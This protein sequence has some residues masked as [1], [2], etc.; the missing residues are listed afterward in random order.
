MPTQEMT[1]K[2]VALR[3]L[4]ARADRYDVREVGGTGLRL[5][6]NP[7]GL[8]T[9]RWVYHSKIGA[10]GTC[11]L[12][13]G[14][15]GDGQNGTITYLQARAKIEAAKAKLQGGL[16]PGE[17]SR[18]SASMTIEKMAEAFYKTRI[19]PF[20][21]CPE[22]A[23][24]VLDFDI[25]GKPRKEGCDVGKGVIGHL[26]FALFGDVMTR[27]IKAA[28]ERGSPGHAVTVLQI[29][30]MIS[31]YAFN[32]HRN[33]YPV[34]LA[35]SLDRKYMGAE[36]HSRSRYLG[37]DELPTYLRTMEPRTRPDR[38]KLHAGEVFLFGYSILLRVGERPIALR[39]ALWEDID[40]KA[41]I[42]TQPPEWQAKK[43]KEDTEKSEPWEVPL[44]RQTVRLFKKLHALTGHGDRVWPVD[45]HAANRAMSRLQARG[46]LKLDAE[47]DPLCVYDLRRTIR[48]GLERLGVAYEICEKVLNHRVRGGVAATY[49]RDPLLDRRREAAQAWSDYLDKMARPLPAN[50]VSI[51][52]A[53]APARRSRARAL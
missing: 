21:K 37:E 52:G 22:G 11:T 33:I 44:S 46:V 31:K 9:F 24:Q 28:V 29:V 53:P 43:K 10:G 7:S 36:S 45:D 50:V 18:A 5:R 26:P 8:K 23:R 16:D 35:A 48:A 32:E 13:L 12:T 19:L 6:V 30:K 40:L 47:K 1:F 15:F 27:P 34:D 25:I 3:N 20:R 4:P 38:K 49:A 2:P 14:R 42:W 51:T 41:G 17:E 39:N